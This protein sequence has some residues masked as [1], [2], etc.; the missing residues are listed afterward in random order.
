MNKLFLHIG[1]G[2]TG[3]SFIQ[4]MLA[5]N[6][7]LLKE[8][9][10]YPYSKSFEDAIRGHIS[11]GNGSFLY[12]DLMDNSYKTTL[13]SSEHFFRE[14]LGKY[15]SRFKLVCNEYDVTVILYSRNVLE[16][17]YSLWGQLVKRKGLTL[18][19]ESYLDSV[20]KGKLGPY[21]LIIKWLDAAESLGF[22]LIFRNYSIHRKNIFKIFLEDA[23]GNSSVSLNLKS[24]TSLIVNRSLSNIEYEFQR[25]FN[26]YD[27]QSG[28][29]I[30][31]KLVNLLPNITPSRPRCSGAS[32]DLISEKFT[33][34]LHEIN[35]RVTPTET[36][37][38]GDRQSFVADSENI[39]E[40]LG[41]TTSQIEVLAG[42]LIK[43]FSSAVALKQSVDNIRDIALKIDSKK[44]LGPE[45]ALFL[46][47]IAQVL[48]PDGPLISKKVLELEERLLHINL[49]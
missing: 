22:N 42:S 29:Y 5:L 27:K 20:A 12:S 16:H 1:H 2:K 11:S 48:R 6:V 38:I 45:D 15:N 44:I 39:G 28:G 41:F 19:F 23:C 14:L 3:S 24:P 33:P 13:L 37:S 26:A 18:N 32:F 8:E 9:F 7:D 36:I 40:A 30:S 34:L 46:L 47:K 43:E 21:S 17:L 10:H 4:S 49:R 25:V 35:G 31:D